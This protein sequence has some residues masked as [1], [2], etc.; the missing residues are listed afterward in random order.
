MCGLKIK[1]AI[2]TG[3]SGGPGQALVR[4]LI[5]EGV[6]VLLLIRKSSGRA[7]YLPQSDL[8]H[9]VD[10]DLQRVKDF[11]PKKADYDVFFHLGWDYT[12]PEYRVDPIYQQINITTTLEAVKLAKRAGCS[13]F[14]GCGSQAEYGRV[15]GILTPDTPCKPEMA[16][17]IA[18]LCA[19]QMAKIL[20]ERENIQFNWL[21]VLSVFGPVDNPYNGF[22]TVIL[23]G[24]NGRKTRLTNGEQIWDVLYTGDLAE[25]FY[26]ISC[27]GISGKTYTI[28]SGKLY[29]LKEELL[30]LAHKLNTEELLMFGEIDYLANQNMYLLADNSELTKD[31][32][33]IPQTDLDSSFDKTIAFWKYMDEIYGKNIYDSYFKPGSIV[34]W[35]KEI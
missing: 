29:T 26:K 2:I 8:V 17:G 16:Y 23:D 11:T 9:V 20:C 32:G 27:K 12:H 15:E 21:R 34:D 30:I 22:S 5:N 14:I 33:W 25:A 31:T 10:C 6:E 35:E 1:K 19:N 13:K 7:K 4:K 24:L 3:A 28:G 18:K